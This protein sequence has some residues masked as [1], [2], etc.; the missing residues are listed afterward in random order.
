MEVDDHAALLAAWS[1]SDAP[2]ASQQDT[3]TAR[4]QAVSRSPFTA[5]K[6]KDK[7]ASRPKARP[8]AKKTQST[9]AALEEGDAA[10]ASEKQPKKTNTIAG[11]AFVSED[12][13]VER[14]AAQ[15]S[16]IKAPGIRLTTEVC[17][18]SLI[19][20]LASVLTTRA[21]EPRQYH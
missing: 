1:Q 9:E 15:S 16:P 5:E 13:G 3:I 20:S 10:P 17:V 7:P 11:P 19:L 21:I 14:D 12:E 4:T 8:R 18:H 2:P 6:T